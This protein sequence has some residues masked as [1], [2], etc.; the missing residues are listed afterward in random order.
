MVPVQTRPRDIF[1]ETLIIHSSRSTGHTWAILRN[2]ESVHSTSFFLEGGRRTRTR[3]MCGISFSLVC[4][5]HDTEE[6]LQ[7][8]M[9]TPGVFSCHTFPFFFSASTF[10]THQGLPVYVLPLI[11]GPGLVD[12]ILPLEVLALPFHTPCSLTNLVEARR[13]GPR[14]RSC[15]PGGLG[16]DWTTQFR[17]VW[18]ETEG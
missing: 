18:H 7:Y 16:S 6:T 4:V 9:G 15:I 3:L 12:S 17:C 10:S 13:G 1:F 11:D 2:P 8:N 14:N 5:R